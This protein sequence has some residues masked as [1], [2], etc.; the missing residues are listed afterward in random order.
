MKTGIIYMATSPSGKIYIGRTTQKL[1]DRKHKHH[2]DA[3]NINKTLY[4]T[5]LSRA[6]RKY[7]RSNIKWNVLYINIPEL[8]LNDLEIKTILY[9]NTY[10]NG[11]NST[12]GG[13]GRS[14]YKLSS[15]TKRKISI[16][17]SGSNNGQY[18]K[19]PSNKTKEK[20]SKASAKNW[21]ENKEK[22]MSSR[23]KGENHPNS[24]LT[25]NDIK[26]I[27]SKYIPYKYSCRKL[28]KEYQI[29]TTTIH[30]IIKNKIWKDEKIIKT[31]TSIVKLNWG[32]VKEIRYKYI[33]YKYSSIK[34]AKEY[35]V[36]D[37]TIMNIINNKTWKE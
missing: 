10:K 28:G 34:L 35:N 19:S 27:R 4:H 2:S 8:D 24:K 29:D 21:K 6:I 30:D 36:S 14:G 26:E 37:K 23:L 32:K 16:A 22:M 12:I 3:F 11:Y 15:I 33:P 1:L 18:G 31:P 7:G 25:W 17:N 5:K 9:Y 20:L 13:E